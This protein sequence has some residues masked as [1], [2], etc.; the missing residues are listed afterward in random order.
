MTGGEPVQLL[1]SE[2]CERNAGVILG[3]LRNWLTAGQQVLEVGSGTGQ[4]VVSFA[5]ELPDTHW[6][7]ADTGY[8]LPALRA[9]LA[10]EAPANVAA[11]LDLDVR[12]EP[13]PAVSFDVVFSANTLHFM[14][15]D[16]VEHFFR[17]V[18]EVLCAGG[19]LVVYG[20]FNYNGRYTSD[21]NAQFDKWLKNTDPVRGIRDIEWVTRLAEA[22]GMQLRQDIA[23]PANNRLLIWC[24]KT[25]L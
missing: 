2:A 23:M 9:R 19:M 15:G 8:Y 24:K 3:E 25:T 18:D 21:S 20:P 13:W 11:A 22:R 17:G 5:S 12:M 14:G 1:Y 7:P 6:Q 16:C 4:H 10:A